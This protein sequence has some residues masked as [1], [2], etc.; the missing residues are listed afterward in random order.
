MGLCFNKE[1]VPIDRLP[2]YVTYTIPVVKFK[3]WFHELSPRQ[4]NDI[5]WHEP[6]LASNFM[7]QG[8]IINKR[9]QEYYT[10]NM[11][12]YKHFLI[13]HLATDDRIKLSGD[14]YDYIMQHIGNIDEILYVDGKTIKQ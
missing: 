6:P 12:I 1:Y 2:H 10:T 13:K 8:Y 11:S 5:I 7:H 3:R 9:T 4:K 14:Q